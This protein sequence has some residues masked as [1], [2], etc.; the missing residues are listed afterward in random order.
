MLEFF[1][2]TVHSQ[3]GWGEVGMQSG[4]EHSLQP[5]KHTRPPGQGEPCTPPST[6][7]Y[8]GCPRSNTTTRVDNRLCLSPE[9][10]KD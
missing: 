5:F 9:D 7:G 4:L 3:P 8:D 10:V 1:P 2:E 6:T